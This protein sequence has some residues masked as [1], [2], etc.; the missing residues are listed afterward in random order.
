M[1][2][3]RRR[4]ANAKISCFADEIDPSVDRQLEL[5]HRLGIEWIEFRSGDGRNVADYMEKEALLL[6]EKLEAAGIGIS[7]LGSPIGKIEITQDFEPHFQ[8]FTALARLADIWET[9]SIRMFSFY[10]PEGEAGIW[11][12]EVMRRTQRMVDYAAQKNLLL[13][14]ENEKGIYGDTAPRCLD[15]MQEFYG[16][17]F[18]CT[19]D[20]ANFVQCRQ[21][22]ME[23][24]EML[25]PYI[26]YVHV[27]DAL[28]ETG[29]VVP[30][31]QGDGQL[32][33]IFEKLDNSGYQ[34]FLSL[35][36]HLADFAGL[37]MLEKD[38]KERKC[39]DG[40]AAFCMAYNALEKLI[41]LS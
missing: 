41:H 31:G 32:A 16:E 39:T 40:E 28:W 20:F 1:R 34:G 7:A 30:A 19:F 33:A 35:E 29:E 22:T 2:M 25:K 26:S 11:R 37:K 18:R 6:K 10:V 38:A 14:H 27:K 5:L 3:E 23:A 9:G 36:P 21:D 4:L 24:Y 13:L 15:L 17:H 12:D 8:K